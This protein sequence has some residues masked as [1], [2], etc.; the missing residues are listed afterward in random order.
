[1]QHKK[2]LT[3]VISGSIPVTIISLKEVI[4][5]ANEDTPTTGETFQRKVGCE[6]K[7]SSKLILPRVL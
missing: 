1:M 6:C 2:G 3:M 4:M 5:E 7:L